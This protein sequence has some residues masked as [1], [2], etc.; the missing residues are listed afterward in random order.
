MGKGTVEPF[1]RIRFIDTCQFLSSSMDVLTKN[2]GSEKESFPLTVGQLRKQGV[3]EDNISL[4]LR[5]GVYPYSYMDGWD[6]FEEGKLPAR[7]KF[8]NDLKGEDISVEE[9]RHAQK[10]WKDLR[11]GTLGEYHDT[12]LMCD[13]MLLADV[14][15]SFRTSAL[16]H[17]K[18]DPAHYYTIP[19]F[20][21]DAFLRKTGVEL[22]LLQDSDMYTMMKDGVRGGI[23]MISHRHAKANNP[24][25]EGYDP[26]KPT[27]YIIY[28]DANN[29][30][31]WAMVQKLPLGGFVWLTKEEVEV[32]SVTG[33]DAEGSLG[34]CWMW[35]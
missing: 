22:E 10:V 23:S 3:S 21:W 18:L 14:F 7:E 4:L 2:L 28:L 20:A 5:K 15:E 30:Y 1:F 33:T 17:Y 16:E 9:Y 11:L 12:Y 34:I 27:S 19:S 29:L 25:A 26:T 24:G 6:K 8:Y 13:V 31:G 35:I 32:F